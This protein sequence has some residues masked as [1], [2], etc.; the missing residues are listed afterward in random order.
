[1]SINKESSCITKIGGRILC[2][3]RFTIWL[4][5]LLFSNHVKC[6]N[7]EFRF[8]HITSEQGLPYQEVEALL[9]DSKGYIWIGTRCGLSRYDGYSLTNYFHRDGH[10][11]SLINN[12]IKK[13]FIDS[14]H[15]IWI[16]TENG[17]CRYQSLTDN[18][19]CYKTPTQ[20]VSSIVESRSGKIICGGKHLYVYNE[21]KD[22]FEIYPSLDFG[23]ILSLAV[24][25][26]NNLFVATNTSIFRYNATMTK[27]TKL[28]S[29][30]YSDFI[31]RSDG[32]IPM[33]FDSQG[34]LWIGR[35]GKGVM[36]ID[37]NKKESK[38]FSSNKISSGIVRAITEDK[39]HNIW[40]GTEKGITI[41]KPDGNTDTLLH[42]F[43][44]SEL[45]K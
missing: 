28:P 16:C 33:K 39:N 17:I 7:T 37:F 44:K 8:R 4:I 13:L 41:I 14:K 21:L 20:E 1:M 42:S 9:Q 31:T 38:I 30:Y 22:N 3:L 32:I 43:Q 40:L 12:F 45:L 34:R 25:K 18:F 36:Y 26:S 19:K 11:K 6:Y 27:I 35:N 5:L 24:D 15:R 10:A 2:I 23:F 29:N